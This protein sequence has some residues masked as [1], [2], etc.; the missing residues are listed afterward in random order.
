M[1]TTEKL[2][3][4]ARRNAISMIYSECDLSEEGLDRFYDHEDYSSHPEGF[5]PSEMYDYWDHIDLVEEIE[6]LTSVFYNQYRDIL[7][8]AKHGIVELAM[9][10]ELDDDLNQLDIHR[11]FEVGAS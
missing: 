2:Y 8:I 6:N 3:D 5:T 1:T 9:D 7:H 11:A 4:K 10:D